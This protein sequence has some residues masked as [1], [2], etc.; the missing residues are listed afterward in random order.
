MRYIIC[1][2]DNKTGKIS[3]SQRSYETLDRAFESAVEDA[4][5][6]IDSL[7]QKAYSFIFGIPSDE[8]YLDRRSVKVNCYE[9]TDDLKSKIP[10]T[11][12]ERFV[13]RIA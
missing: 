8:D 1:R 9:D 4:D 3:F 5:E 12:S 6:E 2:L 11:L 7:I 10:C 13:L